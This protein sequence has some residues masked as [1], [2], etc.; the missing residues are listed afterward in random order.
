MSN[1]KFLHEEIYRGK[2]FI[3][4][5]QKHHLAICGVGTLGSN[6]VDTLVR[7]GFQNI[8]VIDKDRVEAHNVS[9][10]IYGEK[11]VGALKVQAL[12]NR[13]FATTGAEI[14][15]FDKEMN[16]GNVKKCLKDS[17]LVVDAF[18]NAASRQLVREECRAR[19]IPC[20]HA[21]LVEEYGE[22]MWDEKYR[23]PLSGGVDV[24][25]Y[26]LARNLAMFVVSIAA[27]EILD[28]CL[29]PNP[30]KLNWSF[31]LKDLAIRSLKV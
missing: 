24:C 20:L 21:G 18:D 30:R 27:E 3:A 29:A 16:V 8:R 22:V 6:L 11:D 1:N 9:T 7:Q 15:I 26:P 2:D 5:L 14:E 31:T 28:F 17:T 25:E 4:K 19:K 13:M 10:Q 12:R 23:M